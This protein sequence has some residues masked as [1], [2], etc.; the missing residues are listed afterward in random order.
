MTW[1]EGLIHVAMRTFL[2]QDGWVLIAG[3][4]PGGSDHT[5]YPLC[6]VD[7]TVARDDSPDPRRHSLGEMIPDLVALRGADLLF[8]EA[9]PRY[10]Q[11]DKDKLE[12]LLHTR[13]ADLATALETFSRERSFPEL[14]P[15]ERLT[16][17]PVL[18]FPAGSKAPPVSSGFSYLLVQ[19]RTSAVWRGDLAP[20]GRQSDQPSQGS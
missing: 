19:S 15:L 14:L 12:S 7:P 4:F 13:F 18:V 1:T 9:K 10:S 8:A 16:Y 11:A 5:L 6:I 3:E 2:E 17:R 20:T